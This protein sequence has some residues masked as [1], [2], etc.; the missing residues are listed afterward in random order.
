MFMYAG[1]NFAWPKLGDHDQHYIAYFG[2]EKG[3]FELS[4]T[5]VVT[6]TVHFQNPRKDQG[7]TFKL[8]GTK[9]F[10]LQPTRP[11]P[12]AMNLVSLTSKLLFP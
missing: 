7:V 6:S 12:R 2:Y 11:L 4:V 8:R 3:Q 1:V 9:I 5:R 10:G